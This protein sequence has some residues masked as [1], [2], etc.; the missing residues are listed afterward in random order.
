MKLLLVSKE[1]I[2]PRETSG[3][4]G[5]LKRFFFRMRPLVAF[6][7]LQTSKSSTTCAA[8]MWPRFVG[9]RRRKFATRDRLVFQARILCILLRG[10]L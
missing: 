8:N 6:Q 9:F 4:F 5:T 2:A 1:K 10:T 3:A 7:M